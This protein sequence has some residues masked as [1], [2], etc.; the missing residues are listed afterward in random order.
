VVVAATTVRVVWD[1][2]EAL[3]LKVWLTYRSTPKNTPTPMIMAQGEEGS[4]R[5]ST[6]TIV[7]A[8][9]HRSIQRMYLV[10]LAPL[11]QAVW[12]WRTM[13]TAMILSSVI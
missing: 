13:P 6:N 9:S 10:R 3:L 11:D 1:P 12:A 8:E 5:L 7:I 2:E 4:Y